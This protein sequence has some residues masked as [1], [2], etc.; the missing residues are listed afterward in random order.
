MAH[1]GRHSEAIL[2]TSLAGG[3]S[4]REAAALAGVSER[5]AHR[6][7][8][9]PGFRLKVNEAWSEIVRQAVGKLGD[10]STHAAAVLR[11][12]LNADSESVRLSAARSILDHT[13]RLSEFANVEQRLSNLESALQASEKR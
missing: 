8:S 7:W 13:V 1:N 5:T 11:E 4:V 3:S 10:A 2:I 12:L 6:R 9:D